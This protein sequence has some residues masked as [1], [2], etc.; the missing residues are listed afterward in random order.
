M[1]EGFLSAEMR[2]RSFR[3]SARRK[4]LSG[5]MDKRKEDVKTHPLKKLVVY[6]ANPSC[7]YGAIRIAYSPVYFF[8]AVEYLA[9]KP[10][11]TSFVMLNT[12]SA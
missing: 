10:S 4:F 12:L 7:V 5:R 2:L 9:F 6:L 3:T 1:A 8:L 11:T